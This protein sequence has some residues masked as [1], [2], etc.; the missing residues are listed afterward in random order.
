MLGIAP[1]LGETVVALSM[2]GVDVLGDTAVGAAVDGEVVAG[3]VVIGPYVEGDF[4]VGSAVTG[5]IVEGPAVLGENEGGTVGFEKDQAFTSQ[6]WV[7]K[8]VPPEKPTHAKFEPRTP[9]ISTSS[10]PL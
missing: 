7:A 8:P 1:V 6:V 3:P 5:E 2:W 10:D 9:G 4:V